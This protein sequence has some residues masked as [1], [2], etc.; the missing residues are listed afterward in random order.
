MMRKIRC[1]TLASALL[2]VTTGSAFA[3]TAPGGTNPVPP[4]PTTS[5]STS[6]SISLID[7]LISLLGL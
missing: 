5:T 1:F 4:P 2:A 6:T 3:T 7:V